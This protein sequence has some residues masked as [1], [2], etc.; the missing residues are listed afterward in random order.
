MIQVYFS[1]SEDLTNIFHLGF[2]FHA[3]GMLGFSTS[4]AEAS[5]TTSGALGALQVSTGDGD[6]WMS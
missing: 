3:L 4:F 2:S 5:S 6:T 1:T